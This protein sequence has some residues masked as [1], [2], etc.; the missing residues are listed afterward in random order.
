MDGCF[1]FTRTCEIKRE[2]PQEM[3]GSSQEIMVTSHKL[4]PISCDAFQRKWGGVKFTYQHLP[5]T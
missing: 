1:T 3:M 2:V 4:K 5:N